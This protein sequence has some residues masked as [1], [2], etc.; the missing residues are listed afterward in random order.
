LSTGGGARP[1]RRAAVWRAG[2]VLL[3]LV[4]VVAWSNVPALAS[5]PNTSNPELQLDRTIQTTPFFNEPAI[6]MKDSEGSAYVGGADDSLWLAGDNDRAIYEVNPDGTLKRKIDRVPFEAAT[7]P[8]GGPVA[9]PNRTADFESMAYD[10][11]YLYVFSGICCTSSVLPTVFRLQRDGGGQFQVE[12][13]QPLPAGSDFTA[14]AW[15]PGDGNIWVAKGRD[16]RPYDYEAN[17]IGAIVQVPNLIGVLGITFF[18][19]GADLFA[20]TNAETLVRADWASKTVV[21]GWT[22][23]L[24][25]SGVL[26][27]RAV[28]LIGDQVYVSDGYDARPAGDPLAHAVFVYDVVAPA[29]TPPTASFNASPTSG[30]APLTVTFT[31]TSTGDPTPTYSWD[32]GDGQTSTET[33]PTHTY[34]SPDIYDVTLTATNSPDPGGTDSVTHQVTVT[35]SQPPSNLVG[36]PG[37]EVDASGWGTGGSGNGV[38][39]TRV[40][41]GHDGSWAAK[42]NNGSA[43]KRKC[44]LNDQPNWVTTTQAGTYTASIWV[45]DDTPFGQFKLMLKETGGSLN[46]SQTTT[47]TLTTN[48]QLVTVSYTVKSPGTSTLD[49]QAFVPRT[50]AP[51]GTC[52]YADDVSI[53]KS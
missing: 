22:F 2:L 43:R 53:L 32:F 20:V 34:T 48:W 6:S 12:S 35:P 33:S 39:L 5:L 47:V 45:R 50:F 1:R 9:G 31:N 24:T 27:S 38:T 7:P 37:F 25:Q 26:D 49:L 44:V 3:M 10:G 30:E 40:Q 15:N 14:A 52:F 23:S 19:G 51:T 28:E 21:N 41:P 42:L 36:N 18:N 4:G 13:Y 8:G 16:F 29:P 46:G 11:T 17:S